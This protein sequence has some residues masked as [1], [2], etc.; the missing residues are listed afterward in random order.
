MCGTEVREEIQ[1]LMETINK[2]EKLTP[3]RYTETDYKRITKI[4][5]PKFLTLAWHINI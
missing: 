2:K 3:I 4:I 5:I 1:A